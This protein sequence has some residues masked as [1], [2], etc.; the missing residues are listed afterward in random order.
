MNWK[1]APWSSSIRIKWSPVRNAEFQALPSPT[2]EPALEQDPRSVLCILKSEKPWS[3]DNIPSHLPYRQSCRIVAWVEFQLLVNRELTSYLLG[4]VPT[5][6]IISDSGTVICHCWEMVQADD[7]SSLARSTSCWE[8]PPRAPQVTIS[9]PKGKSRGK[10]FSWNIIFFPLL[11]IL[12]V[13]NVW[14]KGNMYGAR[15]MWE[16]LIYKSAF[17]FY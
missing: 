3:G 15:E 12:W 7:L 14:G 17:K 6:I 9:E 11:K 5:I 16:D 13:M 2:W 8:Q 10:H 4:S 1:C